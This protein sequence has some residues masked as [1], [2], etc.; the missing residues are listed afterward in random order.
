MPNCYICDTYTEECI[1][2]PKTNK[3]RHCSECESVIQGLRDDYEAQDKKKK[4][5][6][7]D[8]ELLTDDFDEI[9]LDEELSS[10]DEFIDP[11]IFTHSEDD[12]HSD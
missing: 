7:W 3:L 2:D 8:A 11:S 10:L 1:I 5:G 6:L 4:K 12:V 9:L